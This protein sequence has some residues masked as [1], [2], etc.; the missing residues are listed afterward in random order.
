MPEMYVMYR[1]GVPTGY[2]YGDSWIAQALFM[3]DWRYETE[4]EAIQA[5]KR[6]EEQEREN[7]RIY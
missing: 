4:E 6:F 1:D 5:W 2:A 7:E 3:D